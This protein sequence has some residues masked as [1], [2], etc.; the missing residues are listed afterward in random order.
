VEKADC[1]VARLLARV[2]ECNGRQFP[3]ERPVLAGEPPELPK[4]VTRRDL[5]HGCRGWAHDAARHFFFTTNAGS[6]RDMP[7]TRK[8][9][10][11]GRFEIEPRLQ[12][13]VRPGYSIS[14]EMRR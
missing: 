3:K 2:T 7:H 4:V 14:A 6:G 11:S 9:A 12:E 5:R 8:R 13:M 1:G 10:H